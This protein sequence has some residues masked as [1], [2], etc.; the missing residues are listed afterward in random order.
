[1]SSEQANSVSDSKKVVQLLVCPLCRGNI[2][3]WIV[4]ALARRFMNAKSRSCTNETC[5]YTG[6][7]SDLRK[8]A[9]VDHPLIRPN[10]VDPERQQNWRRLERQRDLGDLI[11]MLNSFGEEMGGDETVMPLNDGSSW[12]TVYFFARVFGPVFRSGTARV[13]RRLMRLWGETRDRENGSSLEDEEND[14][15]GS[16]YIMH[17]AF[18]RQ[19]G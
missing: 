12:L 16:G 4:L 10:M 7:Y 18:R 1:M 9:R 2:K 3:E 5:D 8:H 15:N 14:E 17:V 13:R 19:Y 11:S 6:K